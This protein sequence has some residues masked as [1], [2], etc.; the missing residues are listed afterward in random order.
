MRMRKHIEN[1]MRRLDRAFVAIKDGV[2]HATSK[3]EVA[4]RL[5]ARPA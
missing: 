3:P 1:A 5:P 4:R 2:A